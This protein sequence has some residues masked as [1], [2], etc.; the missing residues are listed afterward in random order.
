MTAREIFDM[1][2]SEKFKQQMY[3]FFINQL[4]FSDIE[5]AKTW[6]S[7]HLTMLHLHDCKYY[8][9][10]TISQKEKLALDIY[11]DI[12]KELSRKRFF[13]YK[14]YRYMITKKLKCIQ[15]KFN[16]YKE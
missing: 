14:E 12:Y 10:L 2:I 5:D 11:E 4:S 8:D 16:V 13:C 6:L 1:S 9:A 15:T 7:V 3:E